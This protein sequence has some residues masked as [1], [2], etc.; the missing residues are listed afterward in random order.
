MEDVLEVYHRP[1][2]PKRPQV[3]I[4]ETS[5]QLVEHVLRPLP[6]APGTL[7]R[8]D[9]EYKRCGVANIFLAVEPLTGHTVVEATE[10]RKRT[11]FAHYLRDLCDGPY[12]EAEKDVVVIDNL[13]IHGIKMIS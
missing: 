13:N 6:A 8:E 11:D 2:D 10:H 9:D 4:D 5:K 12:R 7:A 3:C 1:Y